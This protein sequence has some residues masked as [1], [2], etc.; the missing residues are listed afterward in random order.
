[1]KCFVRRQQTALL[2]LFFACFLLSPGWSHADP[3]VGDGKDFV[4]IV[5]GTLRVTAKQDFTTIRVTR[6]D[7]A[8]TLLW[9]TTIAKA[10][11]MATQVI[12]NPN[13]SALE[14]V[15]ITADKPVLVST[16]SIGRN[17]SYGT[18][19]VSNNNSRF[20]RTFEGYTRTEVMVFCPVVAGAPATSVKIVD[21]T[22]AGKTN[23]DSR[24]L[25]RNNALIKN[26]Q[27]EIWAFNDFDDDQIR[28]T[29]NRDCS[30]MV[31][32]RIRSSPLR[33]WSVI[34][35]AMGKGEFGRSYGTKFYGFIHREMVIIP[36]NNNTKVTIKDL[37]DNDDSRTVTLNRN[38]FFASR[39]FPNTYNSYAQ[40]NPNPANEFDNDFVEI[41][42]DKPIWFYS[43][44]VT[45]DV[46]EHS[47]YPGAIPFGQKQE[48][49]CFVQNGGAKDFQIFA[50]DRTTQV[51]ITT[52]AG[53]NNDNL[54]QVKLGTGT[55]LTPW[56]GPTNGGPV[57]WETD[58]FITKLIRIESTKPIIAMCGDFDR[59]S[60]GSYLFANSANRP[61]LM[62]NTAP[63]TGFVGEAYKY[64][65]TASDPEGEK[66]TY[67]FKTKP[68]GATI[69]GTSGAILWTP[70]TPGKQSFEIEVCDASGVCTTY[71]WDVTVFCKDAV[72]FS[73]WTYYEDGV[74]RTVASQPNFGDI[75]YFTSAPTGLPEYTN[76]LWKATPNARLIAHRPVSFTTSQTRVKFTWYT[77]ALYIPSGTNLTTFTFSATADNGA[78]V[79]IFNSKHPNGIQPNDSHLRFSPAIRTTKNLATY[80]KDGEV[81]RI[82]FILADNGGIADSG[83]VIMRLNGK[84]ISSATNKAPVISQIP[85][86]TAPEKANYSTTPVKATDADNDPL[87]LALT[88]APVGATFNATNGRIS[89]TPK[90]ADIGKVFDFEVTVRDGY[91][92]NGVKRAWKVTVTNVNDKPTI[93]GAPPTSAFVGEQLS[94]KPKVTDPDAGDKHTWSLKSGPPG[95]TVDANTGE[96]K[97]T[98]AA[99]DSDKTA[100]IVIEVCDDGKPKQCATRSFTVTPRTRC[101]VDANCP[102]TRICV[103][104]N[105]ARICVPV[106]CANK[107]PKCTKT[108]DF[109]TQGSCVANPCAS[110]TCPS[111]S[112]CRPNDGKCVRSC[113]TVKCATGQFCEGG[114]CVKDPCAANACGTGR[115][116]DTSNTAK[117]KCIKDPCSTTSCK[118]GR[119][120]YR[121]LCVDDPCASM[122]CPDAKE[123]CVAGQC[124]SR[125]SC[126]VDIDCQGDDVCVGGVCLA[127]GC[128][129]KT[130]KCAG[131]N[132]RCLEATC[133]TDKCADGS[134][135]CAA[136]E[137]CRPTDNKC[138]K[139][140]ASVTCKTGEMCVDGKCEADPCA[141]KTCA[142]G[143][144]CVAGKCEKDNCSTANVC[145]SGR[146]CDTNQNKCLDDPC[147]GVTCP[148]AKQVCRA[149]QCQAPDQCQFDG[150]CP[151]SSI[152]V[153]G[154]CVVPTCPNTACPQ[155]KVCVDG[156][157]LDD[158]CKGVTCQANQYCSG[159]TCVDT[160]AGVFCPKGEICVS[161]SCTKDPCD[162]KQC[163]SG[164]VCRNGACVKD[165][166]TATSCKG[167]RKCDVDKCV[168][169]PCGNVTCPQ[170]Q[171][172]QNGQCGGDRSC[173]YDSDCPAGAICIS[174][175]C[176]PV[177]C[178]TQPCPTGKVCL[179]GT[180]EDDPCA[181]KNCQSDEFCSPVKGGTCEKVCP[182][183]ASGEICVDGKC[184]TDPCDGKQCAPGES[185]QNG[186][187]V[188]DPCQQTGGPQLCRH[189]RVC[190]QD[191]CADDP[192]SGVTCAGGQT[193]RGGAC[194]APKT[195][196]PSAEQTTT[197]AVGDSKVDAGNTEKTPTE[198]KVDA[199]GTTEVTNGDHS[200]IDVIATDRGFSISGGCGC[201]SGSPSWPT[202]AFF[203][204]C[205]IGLVS[206]RRRV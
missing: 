131:A 34:H 160:C 25:T 147:A 60:W 133:Q 175:V 124:V 2:G 39:K 29:S 197:E 152:C 78:M 185:C 24:T 177:N 139:S 184:E 11:Q 50:P 37:T 117:P 176:K 121:G 178:Y 136:D 96:F 55:G 22:D 61:P 198:S 20:G 94:Y 70:S 26:A 13:N 67:K 33:D 79:K 145:K 102:Q 182:T 187:C 164:E 76:Q 191:G 41:I 53:R 15:R 28:I 100:T 12:G 1:M 80:L 110:K 128:Y 188:A 73:D 14:H 47:T 193:C 159:G 146:V 130:P 9:T 200:S 54:L 170:G 169:E 116:C 7:N 141:G 122:T 172:C 171:T 97:W 113:A 63:G 72:G 59:A 92:C 181:G 127:P 206:R 95:A 186:T 192:C 189:Q 140:C 194:Y 105:D 199:S 156:V 108:G 57:Y 99:G 137:F 93:T 81:N 143:E 195:A 71:K 183:C 3:F 16:D 129:T 155:D 4:T 180:C 112:V 132:N 109:C 174:G 101:V 153:K 69:N 19:L 84:N 45:S 5:S 40:V 149:G 21:V 148:D 162:G 64:T 35:P 27:V 98:P 88:K 75:G 10:G 204:L 62:T 157:C 158:P 48:Y 32:H 120:C 151:G 126:L 36:T 17:D 144:V 107:T 51:T 134:L 86:T 123:Q 31:G 118:H 119:A 125:P 65:A 135:T 196:E 46:E 42:S 114:T 23:D 82:L 68:T 77:T 111:G 18:Y 106:G 58:K 85:P 142:A 168:D 150:D 167:G 104:N 91:T 173:K 38:Q 201:Q 138:V 66:L 43:G 161:G 56:L 87:T 166:C 190:K 163:A 202:W 83:N 205:V 154:K 49:F 179:K 8:K 74:V 90:P 165:E 6:L 52:M 89:W 44:P 115:V 30:V 103:Q 203:F